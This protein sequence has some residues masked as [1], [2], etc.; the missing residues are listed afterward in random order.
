MRKS[1]PLV[2]AIATV[3]A[4]PASGLDKATCDTPG[5]L[6]ALEAG[7]WC[8]V[9]G[10]HLN[11]PGVRPDPVPPG[12]LAVGVIAPWSGG[13]YD[14][15][16]DR[17]IVWGGGHMD[18]AG[19]EIYVFDLGTL[20][21]SRVSDPARN[22]G[23]DER[24]GYYPS[25]DGT[26]AV[27]TQQPRAR[28]TYNYVQYVDSIDRFCSVGSSGPYPSGQTGSAHVDCFDFDTHRW[29]QLADTP[30]YG[31]GAKTA[32]DCRTGHVWVQGTV[33]QYGFSELDPAANRW[34]LRRPDDEDL[35][36]V[37][38]QTADIDPGARRMVAIG[39]GKVV[40]WNLADPTKVTRTYPAVRGDLEI[41]GRPAPGLAYDFRAQKLVGWA[42]GTDVFTVEADD[43]NAVVT[44][45][46]A[47]ASNRVAA[48]ALV[49]DGNG[50][51]GRFRYVPSRNLF[52][53]VNGI[54]SN[55]AL[56]R[57]QAGGGAPVDCQSAMV[58]PPVAPADAGADTAPRPDAAV[59]ADATVSA[60]ARVSLDAGVSVDT[61][62]GHDPGAVSDA[63]AAEDAASTVATDDA[64]ASVRASGA[65]SCRLGGRAPPGGGTILA[66][67]ALASL[68]CRRR[69]F[70]RQ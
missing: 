24:S 38:G 26:L 17:L 13:A 42:G 34:S 55:V 69:Y 16:R 3:L 46:P 33:S 59:S 8:E 66:A 58:P 40:V 29:Q 47:A 23:G 43:A 39:Q 1:G 19:N 63:R 44:R 6:D 10:S 5:D 49:A 37:Y 28:H 50:T 22:V 14:R 65:C 31:I 51:F 53:V 15:K 7:Q 70:L 41:L 18:Y 27:D 64:G 4:T 30:S 9:P 62:T 67:L 57:H 36:Y 21:W 45:R 56:Y 25:N 35:R 11:T 61:R 32:Y 2:L 68:A 12:A 60:D 48:A 54:N 20:R 52:I